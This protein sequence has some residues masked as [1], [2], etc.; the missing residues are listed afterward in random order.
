M[1]ILC[2]QGYTPLEVLRGC[3]IDAAATAE[4]MGIE[5]NFGRICEGFIA[6]LIL[7]RGNPL[8]DLNS[9]R[10]PHGVFRA[11]TYYPREIL[12]G[13]SQIALESP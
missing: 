12:A 9:L 13:P 2:E 6:D 7:S 5:S 11:G 8:E 10:N 3:T 1:R 4:K